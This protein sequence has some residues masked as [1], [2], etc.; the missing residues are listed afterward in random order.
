MPRTVKGEKM[1]LISVH[2]PRE[3]LREIDALVRSGKYASRS[4]LIRTAIKLLLMM[5]K[6][7]TKPVRRGCQ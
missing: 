7:T 2:L 5:E 3:M 6:E 4:E 1:V